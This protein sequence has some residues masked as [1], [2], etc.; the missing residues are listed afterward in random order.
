MQ[1]MFV[2]KYKLHLYTC[3]MSVDCLV[4]IFFVLNKLFFNVVCLFVRFCPC[5]CVCVFLVCIFGNY[6]LYSLFILVYS[7]HIP[8]QMNKNR[9]V[10]QYDACL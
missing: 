9:S 4:C 7:H 1:H 3:V 10:Q 2:F 6:T 8:V 5:E